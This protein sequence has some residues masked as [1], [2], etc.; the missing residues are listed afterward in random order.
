MEDGWITKTIYLDEVMVGFTMYGFCHKAN[1]FELCRIM[2]D[3]KFQGKGY[4][5]A[6]I[7]KVIEEMQRLKGCHQIF[8]SF[9]PANQVRKL[10]ERFGFKDTGKLDHEEVV[11]CLKLN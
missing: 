5:T 8:L 1:Y 3:H 6:A 4:G 9:D 2:I 10:Y 7:K 11:Y